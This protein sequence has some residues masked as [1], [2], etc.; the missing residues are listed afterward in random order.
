MTQTQGAWISDPGAYRE[1]LDSLVGGRPPLEVLG[2]SAGTLSEI[3]RA[4]TAAQL[5][6]RPFAG[7]WTPN[8]VIG[9]LGDSELIYGFRI[10]LILSEDRPPIVGVDQELWV[11]AQGHNQ[12][13]PM[14]LV[15]L[16]RDLREHNLAFW[17]RLTPSDLERYGRHNERGDE[18]LATILGMMAGHDLSHIDQI[19]RYL[20]AA[21]A[22]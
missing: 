2:A 12:R 20:A 7:K 22:T 8:E 10:R 3:V 13:E 14:E 21:A 1:R 15:E 9:H 11:A 17:R 19:R 16:F 4:H 6:A 18:S 5:R